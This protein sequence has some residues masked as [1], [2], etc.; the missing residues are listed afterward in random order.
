MAAKDGRNNPFDDAAAAA[1][2]HG[3]PTGSGAGGIGAAGREQST[4]DEEVGEQSHLSL[5]SAPAPSQIS[6]PPASAPADVNLEMMEPD[7]PEALSVD[8]NATLTL[9]TEALIVLDEGLRYRRDGNGAGCCGIHVRSPWAKTTHAIPFYNVLWAELRDFEVE[10]KYAQKTGKKGC[11]VGSINYALTDKSMHA[12]AKHWVEKLMQRAY[13]PRTQRRKRIKVLVNPFGGQGQAMR[14]WTR[15]VEPLFAAAGCEVDMER[16]AYRAHAVE[17][18]EKLDIEAYDVVAAASGDGLPHEV[19]NGLAKQPNPRRALRKIA[20]VQIPCGSGN[21]MSLNC[22]GTD[23]PSLAALA[24]IKGVRCPMDLVAIT[25][26]ARQYYSFLSQATALVAETDLGTESLRWMGPFRFTWGALV[27]LLSQTVYPAEVSVAGEEADKDAIKAS[28]RRAVAAQDAARSAALDPEVFD[29]DL[30]SDPPDGPLPP[31]RYGSVADPLPPAF[32]TRDLPDLGNFYVGNMCL[33]SPAAPF[34]PTSL[35][36]DG[37][38]DMINISALTPRSRGLAMLTTIGDGGL[39]DFPEVRYSKV[40]AYRITPRVVPA[41][42]EERRW[43]AKVGKWLGGGSGGGGKKEEGGLVAVDGERVP[44]EPFQAEVVRGL[45]TVL[46]R[47]GAVWEFGGPPVRA[48][49]K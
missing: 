12:H 28:Y 48:G 1:V 44:F 32:A 35:P 8:R 41:G 49:G 14:I 25:Q 15:E 10:V 5:G 7:I 17:I 3:D 47:R 23:A 11:R 31:L 46:S 43:R 36:A 39:I 6:L 26:G 30:A 2:A 37:R 13:P 33:M 34:F 22:N 42:G 29:P 27:R 20:V 16:T 24:I 21:A 38:M 9:G 45:G 19:F 40:A 4:S 18:A